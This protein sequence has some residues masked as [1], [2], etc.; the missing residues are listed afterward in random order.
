VVNAASRTHVT[1]R[2]IAEAVAHTTGTRA[3]SITREQAEQ[4]LGPYAAVLTRSTPLDPSRA[5]RVVNW[6]PEAPALLDD[7]RTGSY[8]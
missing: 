4:A 2:Q 1:M 8:A 7:L 6:T 3:V 5:E